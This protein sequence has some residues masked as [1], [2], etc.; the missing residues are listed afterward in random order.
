MERIRDSFSVGLEGGSGLRRS[1]SSTIKS[2]SSLA[3]FVLLSLAAFAYR[4][5]L[6]DETFLESLE[7]PSTIGTLDLPL[8]AD[9]PLS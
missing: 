6:A 5:D 2:D 7:T 8:A 4:P 1:L 9:F 3:I